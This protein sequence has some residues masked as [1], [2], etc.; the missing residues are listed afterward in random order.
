MSSMS[1]SVQS[2]AAQTRPPLD[3]RV[4]RGVGLWLLAV[5]AL[6]M[7]TVAV[8]GATRL[9]NSGLSITEWE[10]IRGILPPLSAQEWVETF[11]KYKLTYEFRY[12]NSTMTMDEF[13]YIYNWEWRH[14]NLARLVFLALLIPGILFRLA[15]RIHGDLRHQVPIA[16]GLVL[17]QGLVGW[18]M[19]QSGLSTNVNVSHYRLALHL[20]LAAL[21]FTMLVGMGLG[22]DERVAPR[23]DATL[24]SR[25]AGR[26]LVGWI[27]VMLVL[28]A[29]VA[30]L[31]G[32][33]QHGTWPL[34]EGQFI[35][36]G[37][38][39]MS[40]WPANFVENPLTAQFFHR[41]FA[42]GLVI[43]A[44][45]H[46]RGTISRNEPDPIQRGAWLLLLATFAQM[47]LGI[48]TVINQVPVPL[49]VAHQVL[50]FVLLGM[51]VWHLYE[52]ERHL[53]AARPIIGRGNPQP[54]AR[55]STAAP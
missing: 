8:G 16:L 14:R 37:L 32:G 44:A 31:R 47:L 50:A 11:D 5:A 40:P 33:R 27:L 3:R 29:L 15:G 9:T 43:G 41:L 34:M 53:S 6:V 28:G 4:D 18:L 23:P 12:R 55:S 30:G 48:L 45:L 35:P 21:L 25:F 2:A 36:K 54:R 49:G 42:Y 10:P 38:F 20:L 22:Q 19:V 52:T 17:L 1:P 7:I 13:Q 26:W 51:A 46:W 24:A 39:S